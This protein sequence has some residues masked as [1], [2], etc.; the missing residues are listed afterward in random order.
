MTIRPTRQ[1]QRHIVGL[2]C[3]LPDTSVAERHAAHRV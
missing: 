2:A 1:H 3:I